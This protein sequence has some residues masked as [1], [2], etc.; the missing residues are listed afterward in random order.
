MGQNA[1]CQSIDDMNKKELRVV[2]QKTLSSKDSLIT[3]SNDK[4]FTIEELTKK[5]KVATDSIAIQKSK[6]GSLLLLKK[7][8]DQNLKVLTEKNTILKDSITKLNSSIPL[9]LST[10]SF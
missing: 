4:T 3:V 8:T 5:L 6:I 10:F 1:Y 7:Q 2:L 9:V